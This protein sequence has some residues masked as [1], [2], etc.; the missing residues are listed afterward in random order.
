MFRAFYITSYQRE[1]RSRCGLVTAVDGFHDAGG[2]LTGVI[3]CVGNGNGDT[4]QIEDVLLGSNCHDNGAAGNGDLF[5]ALGGLDAAVL[6]G[7]HLDVDVL[8]YTVG[9]EVGHDGGQDGGGLAVGDLIHHLDDGNDA[10]LLQ[11]ILAN[12]G[13]R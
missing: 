10:A 4:V 3:A 7:A 9:V 12:L 5:L 13:T 6:D 11:Q 8:L 1:I 2:A